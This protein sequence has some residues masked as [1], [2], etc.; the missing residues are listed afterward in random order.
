[1]HNE[2]NLLYLSHP[3]RQSPLFGIAPLAYYRIINIPLLR[4]VLITYYTPFLR[5]I[6]FALRTHFTHAAPERYADATSRRRDFLHARPAACTRFSLPSTADS[7]SPF[8]LIPS[9]YVLSCPVS[10]LSS[11]SHANSGDLARLLLHRN[12]DLTTFT[13]VYRLPAHVCTSMPFMNLIMKL[14]IA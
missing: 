6:L 10:S 2:N 4:L 12:R 5:K 3:P 14:N 8:H 11:P 13:F 1:M 7:S 9:A